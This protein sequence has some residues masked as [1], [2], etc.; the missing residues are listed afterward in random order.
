MLSG[1]VVWGQELPPPPK[2]PTAGIETREFVTTPLPWRAPGPAIDISQ[3]SERRHEEEPR[4]KKPRCHDSGKQE[5]NGESTDGEETEM[6]EVG[7]ERGKHGERGTNHR[8]SSAVRYSEDENRWIWRFGFIDGRRDWER[9]A[10][11]AREEPGVFRYKRPSAGS[12]SKRFFRMCKPGRISIFRKKFGDTRRT[13]QA[14]LREYRDKKNKECED[15]DNDQ[16]HEGLDDE[17]EDEDDDEDGGGNA[18]ENED[19]DGDEDEDEVSTSIRYTDAESRIVWR[20]GYIERRRDWKAL[21]EEAKSMPETFHRSHTVVASLSKRFRKLRLEMSD[22]R[23]KYGADRKE[24]LAK[25]RAVQQDT[26]MDESAQEDEGRR[27]PYSDAES[28]MLWRIAYIQ[29]N[30]DWESVAEEIRKRPDIFHPNHTTPSSL[31]M[32]LYRMTCSPRQIAI[33]AKKFGADIEA[34]NARS[35]RRMGIHDGAQDTDMDLEDDEE[36][37]D[38]GSS[39][40]KERRVLYTDEE[41][42]LVWQFGY[43]EGRK[44]WESLAREAERKPNIFHKTHATANSLSKRY[45]TLTSRHGIANCIAKFGDERD[46]TERDNV[47]R[48]QYQHYTTAECRIIWRFGYIEGRKDWQSLAEE[49]RRKPEVFHPSHANPVALLMKFRRMMEPHCQAKYRDEFGSAY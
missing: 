13:Y 8:E 27:R 34:Y 32:R 12:L 37:D 41:S 24:Y 11:E 48:K 31:S 43:V 44:D 36:Y 23:A 3:S 17:D 35:T 30:R 39:A 4:Q 6:E 9:L 47:K 22:S 2:Q 26:E 25:A 20:F 45:Q 10:Q 46:L 7:E 18:S 16:I 15:P 19:G 38:E 28:R 5:T 29:G 40:A 49:A 1:I 14:K 33:Y 21:V 42:R